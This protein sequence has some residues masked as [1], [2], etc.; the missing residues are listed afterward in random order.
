MRA[1]A[2][3]LVLS[4]VSLGGV[5]LIYLKLDAIERRVATQRVERTDALDREFET[6]T[7]SSWQI[8]PPPAEP[9]AGKAARGTDDAP[10]TRAEV[11]ERLEKL[12]QRLQKKANPRKKRRVRSPEQLAKTLKLTRTQQDQV[13][14][15]VQ[16]GRLRVEQLLKTP[17]RDGTSVHERRERLYGM[18]R[19]SLRT[20]QWEDTKTELASANF[21]AERLPGRDTTIG[22]E[23][24][25]LVNE[26]RQAIEATLT[27]DQR[28][29]YEWI[30]I[31]PMVNDGGLGPRE[32]YGAAEAQVEAEKAAGG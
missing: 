30:E 6:R 20:G 31:G 18:I 5:V 4:A 22:E 2:L 1:S 32:I 29:A 15:L 11:D 16:A 24:D 12:E 10:I 26:T 19:E 27:V 9:T 13:A 8:Y 21:R 17:G 28:T 3:A 25:R 14:A 23:V 7:S